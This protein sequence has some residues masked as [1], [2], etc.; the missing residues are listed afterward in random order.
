MKNIALLF[1]L[2]SAACSNSSVLVGRWE[3]DSEMIIS[4]LK[5]RK[6]VP[7]KILNCFEKKACGHNVV[8]EYTRNSW[9]QI[10]DPGERVSS[11][12]DYVEY[13]ILHQNSDLIRIGT[14]AMG[15]PHEIT[16]RIVNE[17]RLSYD[18]EL[19]GFKWTEHLK[20]IR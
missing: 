13:V 2:L 5:S 8:F 14:T 1:L 17:N 10:L 4:E 16:F 7:P 6:Y 12:S 19:D 3:Y 18:F 11:I 20:R 9:R 15:I